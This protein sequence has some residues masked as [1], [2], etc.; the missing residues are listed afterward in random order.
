MV[1]DNRVAGPSNGTRAQLSDGRPCS[2]A[3]RLTP[4]TWRALFLA[5]GV[6]GGN[7]PDLDLLLGLPGG[8]D[9]LS[10]LLQHRGYTHTVLGCIALALLLFTAVWAWLSRRN[11]NAT[12]RERTLLL[13]WCLAA[14]GLHL[15]MDALNSYGVHPFWPWRNDW[16]YGDAVF[17]VEPLYWAAA[18]PL[19]FCFESR[20]ARAFIA[21]LLAAS[22]LV[23]LWS[24]LVLPANV[25]GL[26]LFIGLLLGAT[27]RM[28][29]RTAALTS[30]AAAIAVTACFLLAG[31]VAEHRAQILALRLS[32]S[33][34]LL[35][36]VLTPAP[37]NPLCW[38]V[39]L[40]QA[41]AQTYVVRHVRLSLAPMVVAASRCPS[42]ER[43]PSPAAR[44]EEAQDWSEVRA[45]SMA[46]P[47]L[48]RL[49][50]RY[51]RVAALLQFA[52]APFVW[53]MPQ[54]AVIGDARFHR[55]AEL[56]FADLRLTEMPTTCP[57]LPPWDAPRADL[58][59]S[60][61]RAGNGLDGP[62]QQATALAPG[63]APRLQGHGQP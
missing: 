16:V 50:A 41:N 56:G 38:D 52:R 4:H 39:L 55:E 54:G 58:L 40:L 45:E 59:R 12:G 6:I 18:A 42:M 51:C 23:S 25:A 47:L 36:A 13:L 62:L 24:G 57:R 15:G 22:I 37:A 60:A 11:F 21:L 44:A 63:E 10:Y 7:L 43:R 14:V 32:P 53:Q 2:A 1:R 28:R 29:E 5:I 9:K 34:S 3:S 61:P 31:R 26:A 20:A 27:S 17:I 49:A 33:Q 35:D 48:A 30:V 8:G 46:R 19:L